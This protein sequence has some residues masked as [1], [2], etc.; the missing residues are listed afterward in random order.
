MLNYIFWTGIWGQ[1]SWKNFNH[2][3]LPS[4]HSSWW[5][6]V[7]DVLKT[8][9]RCLQWTFFCF[10][11]RPADTSWRHLEDVLKTSWRHLVKKFWKRPGDVLK[12]SLEGVPQTHL[13]DVLKTSWKM[14]NCYTEEVFKTSWKTRNV[15]WFHDYFFVQKLCLIATVLY[16]NRII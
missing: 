3:T 1:T 13:E 16:I 8:S 5:R 15:C 11:R 9:W 12:T 2:K 6:R 14:K 4:K 10:P 7:E